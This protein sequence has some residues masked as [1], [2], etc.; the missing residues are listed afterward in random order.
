MTTAR[1][2]IRKAMQKAKIL[3]K[4]EE[5]SADE[6]GDA[7]DTL[8]DLFG[9]IANETSMV[10][11]RSVESFPLVANQASYTIG[12]GGDFNTPRPVVIASGFVRSGSVDYPLSV[13]AD[14]T[15]D[16]NIDDK[17]TAS[18]PEFY[19]Y[20]NAYPLGRITFY[21]TPLSGYTAYLRMEKPLSNLTLDSQIELPPGWNQ[22]LV[23]QLAVM[24]APEYGVPVD[25][26]VKEIAASSKD[27]I[28]QAVE[29]NRTMDAAPL[30]LVGGFDIY[31]GGYR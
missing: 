28:T 19:F 6:A 7:L 23:Y 10:S 16:R 12:A 22:Y 29:K 26:E 30:G 25:P 21:P 11:V 15:Y 24:L 8:N 27:A 9:S 17:D 1:T 2:I 20:D 4:T 31:S 13:I 14:T 3:T 5:P 18:I